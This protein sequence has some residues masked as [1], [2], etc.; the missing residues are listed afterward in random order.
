MSGELACELAAVGVAPEKLCNV[1]GLTDAD[2][3]E[4][5]LRVIVYVLKVLTSTRNEEKLSDKIGCLEADRDLTD[6]LIQIK[7]FADLLLVEETAY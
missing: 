3:A 2:N 7:I 5:C 6:D 1:A 4:V